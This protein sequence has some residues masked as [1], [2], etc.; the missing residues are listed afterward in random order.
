MKKSIIMDLV[1]GNFMDDARVV[2]T[3]DYYYYMGKSIELLNSFKQK[4]SAEVF[5]DINKLLNIEVK[6][7]AEIEDQ[8]FLS[9]FK[10]GLMVGVESSDIFDKAERRRFGNKSTEE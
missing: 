7:Q 2:F 4:Y 3:D 10:A 6:I 8:E 1:C 9:G 5:A